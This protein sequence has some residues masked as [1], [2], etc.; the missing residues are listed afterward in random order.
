VETTRIVIEQREVPHA[1]VITAVR[2]RTRAT[3]RHGRI[4]FCWQSPVAVAVA[5]RD[6]HAC[7]LPSGETVTPGELVR[8]VPELAPVFSKTGIPW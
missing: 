4:W 3:H 5:G 1:T 7:F 2:R 8:E 6:W